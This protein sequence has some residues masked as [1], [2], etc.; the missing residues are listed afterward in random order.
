MPTRIRI[1]S[2]GYEW[3]FRHSSLSQRSPPQGA[4]PLNGL[5]L[6]LHPCS[7]F[8]HH[9]L[10][11]LSHRLARPRPLSQR[12]ASRL[13]DMPDRYVPSI[14]QL[15]ST[16]VSQTFLHDQAVT[17]SLWPATQQL[18]S[19]LALWPLLWHRPLS[20]H[21]TVRW[22]HAP[23]HAPPSFS[24]LPPEYENVVRAR[25]GHGAQ[26]LEDVGCPARY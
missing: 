9:E 6:A 3:L 17:L 7:Q 13:R 21:A 20:S 11:A 22:A 2:L 18:A 10:Q 14:P 5:P 23:P 4:Y 8:T 12:R 16:E 24:R 15:P 26:A 25:Y 19:P 1:T